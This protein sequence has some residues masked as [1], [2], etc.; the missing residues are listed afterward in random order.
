[1]LCLHPSQ[2]TPTQGGEWEL[3]VDKESSEVCVDLKRRSHLPCASIPAGA[4]NIRK[5][6]TFVVIIRCTNKAVSTE[7]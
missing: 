7:Q 1:M 4:D 2:H 5:S 6:S 3:R